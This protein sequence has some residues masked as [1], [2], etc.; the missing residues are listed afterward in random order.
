MQLT[1]QKIVCA[2]AA[3]AFAGLSAATTQAASDTWIAGTNGDYS[4][5]GNWVGGNVPN[6]AADVATVDGDGSAVNLLAADTITLATLSLGVNGGSPVFNHA[7]ALTVTTLALGGADAGR[8]PTYDMTGGTLSITGQS[9]NWGSGNNVQ[10][11]LNGG[12]VNYGAAANAATIGSNVSGAIGTLTINDG[13][14]NHNGTGQFQLGRGEGATSRLVMTGGT[15]NTNSTAVRFGA[16]AGTANVELSGTAVFNVTNATAGAVQFYM[17]NNGSFSTLQ[18]SDSAQLNAAN[19]TFVIGQFNNR[20]GGTPV[21]TAAVSMDGGTLRVRDIAIGGNNAASAINGSLVLNGG[22]VEAGQ[23]RLGSSSLG[24]N[25]TNNFVSADGGT[26]RATSFAGNS[27]FFQNAFVD[28][29][30]G[31]LSFDTNGLSVTIANGLNGIGGL[32]KLGTGTLSLTG[33]SSYTGTTTISSGTLR[34]GVGDALA[35]TSLLVLNAG[36]LVADGASDTIGSLDV[37]AASILQFGDADAILHALT[38]AAAGAGTGALNVTNWSDGIDE[39]LF[40]TET[41][42]DSIAALTTFINPSG[43][44]G[45]VAATVVPSGG[46]FAVVPVPEPAGLAL[47]GLGA[48]A[49]LARRRRT[50]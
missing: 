13:T 45:N 32:T 5:T 35:D 29:Q 1:S 41:A 44:P 20:P 15:L 42:A 34:L 38:F 36:T 6:G 9:F 23:I 37:T 16:S 40:T 11:E 14:F 22:T 4:V 33:A 26:I 25:A 17:S 31:G 8:N 12:T 3:V 10:F 7:G 27:N 24:S 21:T 28:L 39:F 47:F 43:A 2:V 49:V 46:N 50:A 18:M 19:Q 48:I 30:A